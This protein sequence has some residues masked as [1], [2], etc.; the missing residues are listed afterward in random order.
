MRFPATQSSRA[1]LVKVSLIPFAAMSKRAASSGA[2]A[3]KKP[4]AVAAAASGA[5]A[6]ASYDAAADFLSFVNAS[7]SP[8]HAVAEVESRLLKAGTTAAAP[9]FCVYAWLEP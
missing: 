5:G 4:R 1:F 2:A 7:P 3:T 9:L 6:S 8:F